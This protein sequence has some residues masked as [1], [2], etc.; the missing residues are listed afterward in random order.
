MATISNNLELWKKEAEEQAKKYS[1]SI[2]Q[3]NQY[4]LDQ[5][6]QQKQNTLEQLQNQQNN[7]IYNLNTNKST[8]NQTAEDNAKQANI[9]RLLAL[10]SNEQSL[11]RAGLGTQGIVGSQ[12]AS[13]NNSYGQNLT[14][15]LNQKTSDLRELEKEKNDTLLKYNENRLNLSNEYDANLANLQASIDDKALNQYNNVYNNYLAMKQQ[16]Y[17]NEQN[18]LAQEEAIR[19]YNEQM[20]YKKEQDAIA[21]ARAWAQI[22]SQK[23][24][25]DFGEENNNTFEENNNNNNNQTSNEN[26]TYQGKTGYGNISSAID[27]LK[28]NGVSGISHASKVDDLIAKGYL[29]TQTVNGKMYYFPVIKPT[30]NNSK[31]TNNTKT[32]SNNKK[33]NN[34]LSK[35]SKLLFFV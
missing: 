27:Y 11:N 35:L 33:S 5:L 8:I 23:N 22:N 14:S 24:S 20:A 2:K 18:R 7:A 31:S 15:I 28:K 12:N 3:N 34:L 21:N 9:N 1:D 29:T 32:S 6:N 10:K 30:T 17:E 25:Y 26:I 19:Q 13:I 4:L 16:E